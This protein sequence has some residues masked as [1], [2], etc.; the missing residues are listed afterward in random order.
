MAPLRHYGIANGLKMAKLSP[1]MR[2]IQDRYR[3]LSLVD[4]VARTCS[5]RSWSC[6]IGTG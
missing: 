3:G 5:R 6:T 1:E 2:A 4:P